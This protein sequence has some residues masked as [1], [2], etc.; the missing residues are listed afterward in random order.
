MRAELARGSIPGKRLLPSRN[1]PDTETRHSADMGNS[2]DTLLRDFIM[3]ADNALPPE[4]CRRLIDRF[5]AMEAHQLDIREEAG[6]SFAQLG[7]TVAWPDEQEVLL[8]VFLQ[9]LQNYRQTRRAFYWPPD[10]AYEHLRM[11][12]YL[13]N[14]RDHF[15]PH[16]D[17]LDHS[18]SRRFMT[19]FIYLNAPADGETVFPELDLAIKPETGRLLAFPPLWLFPHEGRPPSREPKYILHMYLCYRG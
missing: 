9:H 19:A 10:M 7:I 14:G 4:H 13:P 16:V 8:P 3:V 18:S 6:Y 1:A 2:A 17:V 11:K 15:E 5:E 12:R